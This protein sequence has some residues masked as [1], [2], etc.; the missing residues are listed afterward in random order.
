MVGIFGLSVS[1][2]LW[3]RESKISAANS[4][5]STA[6]CVTATVALGLTDGEPLWEYFRRNQSPLP[7]HLLR[8]YAQ[9][10]L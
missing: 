3:A 5:Y 6:W 4:G 8:K 7:Q 2:A 10:V 9:F 1:S